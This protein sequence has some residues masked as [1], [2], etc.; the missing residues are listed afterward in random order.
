MGAIVDIVV[1]IRFLIEEDGDHGRRRPVALRRNAFG[2]G[3]IVWR[4][5]RLLKGFVVDWTKNDS[6]SW[7]IFL[8][9]RCR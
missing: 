1:P 8:A 2:N 9:S 4:F 7:I 6:H 3:I 5:V